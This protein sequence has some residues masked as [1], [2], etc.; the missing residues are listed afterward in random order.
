M[1]ELELCGDIEG[2]PSEGLTVECDLPKGHDGDHHAVVTWAQYVPPPPREPRELSPA[3]IL[4]QQI[5]RPVLESALK[6]AP[7]NTGRLAAA[8]AAEEDRVAIRVVN[9]DKEG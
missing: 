2:D 9:R 8:F 4:M 6:M 7:V 5:W 3:E 1:A